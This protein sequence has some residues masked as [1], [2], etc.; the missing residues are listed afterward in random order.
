MPVVHE[1]NMQ[2]T[3]TPGGNAIT[4]VATAT[5][6]AHEVSVIRQRQEPGGANP[7]HT[8]DR[9]EV[10][11][12]LDGAINLT[13]DGRAERLG[14]GDTAIIPASTAHQIRN[15][16]ETTA[17]WLIVAPAGIRYFGAD[18]DEMFPAWAK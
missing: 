1:R 2:V 12:M 16:G 11:T 13:L 5:R 6:G 18:G 8:H 9:E 10:L 7:P 15:A 17:E 4:P 3:E 14:P